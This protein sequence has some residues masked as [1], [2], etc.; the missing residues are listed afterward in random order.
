MKTLGKG[1]SWGAQ[2]A[3][4]DGLESRMATQV[5]GP[6]LGRA[7]EPRSLLGLDGL[8]DA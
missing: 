2:G 5:W 1:E 6:F 3:N 4:P 8:E 7:A